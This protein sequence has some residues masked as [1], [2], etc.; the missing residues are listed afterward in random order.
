MKRA[1][2]QVALLPLGQ[3]LQVALPVVGHACFPLL[4][5]L[6]LQQQQQQQ[7]SVVIPAS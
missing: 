1:P 2:L 7:H 3:A 4:L 5:P 6:S